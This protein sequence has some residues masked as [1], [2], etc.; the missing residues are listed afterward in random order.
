MVESIDGNKEYKVKGGDLNI[1]VSIIRQLPYSNKE[2][3]S[4]F[5]TNLAKALTEIE[6]EK[7][8]ENGDNA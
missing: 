7:E 8:T 1:L 3:I 6:V 4:N 2:I 5:E